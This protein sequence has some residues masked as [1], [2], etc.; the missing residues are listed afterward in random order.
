MFSG[1]GPVPRAYRSRR[2]PLRAHGTVR[3][4]ERHTAA[5]HA[6]VRADPA[7]GCRG[8]AGAGRSAVTDPD[9]GR[10]PRRVPLDGDRGLRPAR[11]RGIHR[12]PVRARQHR[13]GAHHAAGHPPPDTDRAHPHRPGRR[14]RPAWATEPAVP[15]VTATAT[16]AARATR[17]PVR[18]G[19][20]VTPFRCWLGHR[21]GDAATGR[22][23]WP[24]GPSSAKSSRPSDHRRVRAPPAPLGCGRGRESR[25]A[26]VRR[27]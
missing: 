6:A 26:D 19:T 17:I 24:E 10:R 18:A 13:R 12:G 5:H 2:R 27:T 3:R 9:R 7:S 8:P 16:A 15:V 21:R 20:I 22:M 25:I 23:D 11:G 14:D 4:S 1:R